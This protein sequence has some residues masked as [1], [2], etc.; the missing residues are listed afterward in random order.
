MD[1]QS[2]SRGRCSWGV[3]CLNALTVLLAL[4]DLPIAIT[5]PM[6][7]GMTEG[8][9]GRRVLW[10]EWSGGLAMIYPLA[11]IALVSL[12]VGF[13]RDHQPDKSL[14]FAIVPFFIAVPL[15]TLM[16]VYWN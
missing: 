12:S 14:L 11:A 15:I 8:A 16:I 10:A 4:L 9:A 7:I 1:K 13:A 3:I 2:A 5:A 6:N